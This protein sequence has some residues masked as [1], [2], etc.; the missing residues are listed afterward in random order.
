MAIDNVTN[1]TASAAESLTRTAAEGIA[2]VAAANAPNG[3]VAFFTVVVPT[4]FTRL[5]ELASAPFRFPEVQWIVLPLLVTLILLEVYFFR[6][7]DEELG[8]NTA[9]ANG[10]VL[11]FIGIDLTRHLFDYVTPSQVFATIV[12][13][14]KEGGEVGAFMVP[15]FLL[16]YGTVITVLSFFHL[17][18]KAIAYKLAN[19]APVN[20]LAY[21]AAVAVYSEK[22]GNPVPLDAY[23]VAAATMLFTLVVFTIFMV[24]R[25]PGIRAF[26]R[27]RGGF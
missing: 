16:L 7:T 6:N 23:T 19:H 21:V 8:W 11:L 12:A 2:G 4:L 18:P 14:A 15:L 20:F 27:L 17:L 22:A 25:T 26:Q 10:L 3:L 24:Q 9:V 13:A 5:W 1:A